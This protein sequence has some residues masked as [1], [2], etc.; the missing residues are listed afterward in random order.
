MF[1]FVSGSVLEVINLTAESVIMELLG[2]LEVSKTI[3]TF[4]KQVL[5]LEILSKII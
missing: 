1:Y 3:P 2:Y 4:I 5:L